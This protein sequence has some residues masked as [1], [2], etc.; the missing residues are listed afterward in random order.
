MKVGSLAPVEVVGLSGVVELSA[1]GYFPCALLAGGSAKCCGNNGN[2]NLG[3]GTNASSA[4]PADVLG[5]TV[6]TG[7]SVGTYSTCALLAGGHVK[8]WG[9]NQYGELGN[10]TSQSWSYVPVD[11]SGVQGAIALTV[12]NFHACV[13]TLPGGAVKCWGWNDS[14]ML[15]N[16]T[17]V[18][19][20][21]GPVDVVD[22][23]GATQISSRSQ[24]TCARLTGGTVECWGVNGYGQ[25]GDRTRT[26]SNVPV[27]VG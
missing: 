12:S 21:A 3:N 18:A 4:V 19:L 17:S 23:G 25:L 16:G 26:S 13:L 1:G 11:V 2:G 22:L 5:I 24:H 20:S 10:G 8:C 7:I 14:G 15:G 6:A 27:R 9:A